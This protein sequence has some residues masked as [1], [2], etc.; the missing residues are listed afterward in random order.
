MAL[1]SCLHQKQ[2]SLRRVDDDRAGGL[3]ARVI[4]D[5]LHVARVDGRL[6]RLEAGGPLIWPGSLMHVHRRRQAGLL[7][8]MRL[9]HRRRHGRH[10]AVIL[11]REPRGARPRNKNSTKPPPRSPA[12][13]GVETGMA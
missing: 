12:R 6:G 9:R 13:Y 1:P 5:L 3:L 8:H 4:H 11:V 7:Q 10:A 2:K